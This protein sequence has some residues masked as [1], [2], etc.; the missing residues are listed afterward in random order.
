M[1]T[2][3]LCPSEGLTRRGRHVTKTSVVEFAIEMKIFTQELLHIELNASSSAR[4][5]YLAKA[6][7]IAH[8]LA[9]FELRDNLPCHHF[10]SRNEKAWKFKCALQQT[11]EPC[12]AKTSSNV[13]FP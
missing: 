3:C 13:K 6:K 11:E 12:R 5:V 9:S 8:L 7:A 10:M 1:E 2:R 4:T